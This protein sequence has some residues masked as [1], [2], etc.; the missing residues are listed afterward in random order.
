MSAI[1]SRRAEVSIQRY[2]S[3]CPDCGRQ[4]RQMTRTVER[5]TTT[6]TERGCANGQCPSKTDGSPSSRI[7]SETRTG[8]H[9]DPSVWIR[10]GGGV[11]GFAGI[12]AG[13]L[14]VFFGRAV[15]TAE[16][17]N[18]QIQAFDDTWSWTPTTAEQYASLMAGEVPSRVAEALSAMRSLIG[19]NDAM[20]YLVNMAPRLV[21]LHRVL[22]QTGSLYLHCDPTMSHDLKVLLDAIFDARSFRNE[23]SWKRFSA[24]N[25]PVRFGRTHDVILFY[26]KG[27]SFTWNTQHGPFEQ[28]YVDENYR[29]LEPETG[30]RYRHG[31]LTAAKPGGDVSYEWHGAH[32][33][34]GRASGR[35]RKQKWIRY[36]PTDASNSAP[37]ACRCSSD[38]ST[39][40]RACPCKTSGPTSGCTPAATSDSDTRPKSRLRS[41]SESSWRQATHTAGKKLNAPPS[42][43]PYIPADRHSVNFEQLAL[44]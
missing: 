26:T 41:S 9:L 33:Y 2:V 40:N 31:D 12:A 18:A 25:D 32:P 36:S 22:K 27:K 38:T 30:R 34:K 43:L 42:L 44:M 24:K 23:I 37:P 35:T 1:T 39:S 13:S 20:A 10:V 3:T 17:P 19:E 15:G 8:H 5:G 11:V 4:S 6:V 29:F 16:T 14:I 28:D 7:I 21:E